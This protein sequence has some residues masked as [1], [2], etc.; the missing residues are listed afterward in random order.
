M[1][2]I[3][4][5]FIILGLAAADSRGQDASRK[6][7]E[8]A[9]K[10]YEWAVSQKHADDLLRLDPADLHASLLR[11]E[12][13]EG[14]GHWEEALALLN[15][16]LQKQPNHAR[17]LLLRSE[18]YLNELLDLGAA[19]ADLETLLKANPRNGRAL[20]VR[21]Q[22]YLAR[23]RVAGLDA[24]LRD[25]DECIR[26]EPDNPSGYSRR[27]RV[28]CQRQEFDKAEADLAKV[29]K[30]DP[31]LYLYEQGMYLAI[32]KKDLEKA[33]EF[34]EQLQ[35]KPSAKC[36][37]LG[38][39]GLG[40]TF[41]DEPEREMQEVSAAIRLRPGYF[42][43]EWRAKLFFTKG[44]FAKAL[45]DLEQ[46][47]R[48]SPRG[49]KEMLYR[50][51]ECLISLERDAEA[52]L[53]LTTAL[54]LDADFAQAYKARA[55]AY[56]QLENFA[57]SAK[58]ASESLR[59]KPQHPNILGG[60]GYCYFALGDYARAVADFSRSL[61]LDPTLSAMFKPYRGESYLYLREFDKAVADF[62]DALALDPKDTRSLFNRGV[63]RYFSRHLVPAIAD[64]DEV[65]RRL[66]QEALC[67]NMR[68]LCH[69]ESGKHREAVADFSEGM[70]LNPKDAEHL[71]RRGKSYVCLKEY[72]KA[73]ADLDEAIRMTPNDYLLHL[74]RC[75]AHRALG[76]NAESERDLKTARRLN[77][78]VVDQLTGEAVAA[79]DPRAAIEV[80]DEMVKNDPTDHAAYCNRAFRQIELHE[81]AAALADCNRC[82]E[83]EPKCWQAL[84]NRSLIYCKQNEPDKAIADC[85]RGIALNAESAMFW[86]HRSLAHAQKREY[87]KALS[88]INEAIRLAPQLGEQY[89]ARSD[90]WR[91]LD[92]PGKALE[93]LHKAKELGAA[94]MVRAEGTFFSR[95][96]INI[97]IDAA[98]PPPPPPE[99]KEYNP[100][101]PDLPASV[102]E[103]GDV[104]AV[105]PPP[106]LPAEPYNPPPPDL[107]KKGP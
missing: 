22:L 62:D 7:A 13:L 45:E 101:P 17:A 100:R 5:A 106:T 51:G 82:L 57:L 96:K 74:H 83:L 1:L 54:E 60:R 37:T 81:W 95:V 75:E 15:G 52:I 16:V 19:L 40:S 94:G 89:S 59:L 12:A 61:E 14:Q 3:T 84:G 44:D 55:I 21:A 93:D 58:D 18:I 68:G 72:A 23:D 47:L 105:P 80:Y 56:L 10:Q 24:S 79:A 25:Y 30:L 63:V 88:D 103:S 41:S 29:E 26:L 4:T 27:Y 78:D 66:P 71:G 2:Q 8:S 38:H 50:K 97:E 70:K 91:I 77:P 9:L 28:H 6:A 104:E 33:R 48:R 11:A 86:H 87:Q 46:C 49:S 102:P 90:L 53:P 99:T 35:K 31:D 69:Y 76:N 43:Y 107:P 34:F 73:V 85:N 39:V 42:F 92:E 98:A 64:L 36:Q 65:I 32:V 67:R 20:Y